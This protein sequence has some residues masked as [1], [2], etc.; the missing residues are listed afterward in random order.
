MYRIFF[1]VFVYKILEEVLYVQNFFCCF[2][3]IK[4]LEEV[5]YVQNFFCCFC[6]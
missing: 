1:A 2:L 6:I 4:I 3:Y 5:L